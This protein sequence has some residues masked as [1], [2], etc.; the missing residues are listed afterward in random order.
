MKNQAN[1]RY[2]RTLLTG[3]ILVLIVFTSIAIGLNTGSM[4]IALPDLVLTLLGKGT[5]MHHM[6]L[7]D[8]RLPRILITM[9]AGMGLGIAGAMLQGITRNALADP[10]ILGIHAGASFG[11][12]IYVSFFQSLNTLPV[13]MIPL[14]T[15]VGG[16]L[17][18]TLIILFVWDRQK[19][20]IPAR[21][22]LIGIAVAA[23]FNA[24]SLYLSLQLDEK[25]YSFTASWLLGNI[26]G[27]D[28]INVYAMLPWMVLLIPLAW[29]K[30]K[31]LNALALEDS[32]AVSIGTPVERERIQILCIAVALSSVSVSMAGGIGFIGLVAPH[33]ARRLVGPAFQ[34]LIPISA[35]LGM[36]ILV[37]ADTVT[38]AVFDPK[39]IP[40][41]IV[42]AAV[43]APYFL[44]LL[45]KSNKTI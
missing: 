34:Y 19:G 4:Q 11:L 14:F 10:G 3:G 41:G 7:F 9:L 43:G 36:L 20:F 37:V 13:L 32:S 22:I 31:S 15:F 8:Y 35:L 21:L 39:S 24:A 38:R 5:D 1:H 40:A 16:I 2:Q 12:L 6:V 26:W 33:M 28:W 17:A 18:A 30:S 44:Y 42:V 23:G 29:A 27:R 25:T 45:R